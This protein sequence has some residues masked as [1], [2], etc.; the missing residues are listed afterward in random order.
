M[1]RTIHVLTTALLVAA[2]ASAQAPG[3][4]AAALPSRPV[5]TPAK[6]RPMQ[7]P[8]APAFAD[9][10]PPPSMPPG[11]SAAAPVILEEELTHFDDRLA[12]L[13]WNG[14]RYQLWAGGQMLKDFGRR[15]A[16]GRQ[17]L[18]VIR[19][20]HLT[21]R[22]TVGSPRPIMEYWLSDGRVPTSTLP[23]LRAIPIDR[24]TLRVEAV[25]GYWCV[26]DERNTFFNFGGHQDEA[27]RA[28][29]IMKQHA[30]DRLGLI[31]QGTPVML[32]FLGT[33]PGLTATPLHAPPPPRGR[34]VTQARADMANQPSSD[35]EA[36]KLQPSRMNPTATLA[37]HAEPNSSNARGGPSA[38]SGNDLAAAAMTS[39][40]QLAP[41][42]A[43]SVD[44]A[45]LADRIPL[46]FRQARLS[47]DALGWK[48]LCGNYVV[49][50]F[51][52]NEREAK[53]GEMAFRTSRFTEQCVIGH[54]KP[55]FTYF[56][57]NGQPPR[58]LPL[59][60]P[61]IA[62]RPDDLSV[63]QINGAW[64]IC[65]FT[66]PLFAFGDKAEE[67]KEALKAI[68][69]HRFDAYCRLGQGDPAMTILART[70]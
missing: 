9:L 66:R 52:P 69:K 6:T 64:T 28:L 29:A 10:P 55:V 33:P 11:P 57:A 31:G 53:L 36:S 20:L 17:A 65:D 50:D 5:L 40:R 34:V 21:Q 39:N 44:L 51:G 13:L 45:T 27:E 8:H 42:S 49:A 26:R 18:T 22:G 63:R 67:A 48:L 16:D 62:F 41:P 3:P 46:D 54:P 38:A 4:N 30:V 1:R 2:T 56:L 14:G 7:S 70:R 37:P 60:A 19:E 68:Q 24:T 35:I 12:D 15:E 47:R 58:G 32:V 43:R 23:G 61:S 25:Q 59:G